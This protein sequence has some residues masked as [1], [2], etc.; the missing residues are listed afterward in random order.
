[1]CPY[2]GLIISVKGFIALWL[3]YGGFENLFILLLKPPAFSFA[4]NFSISLK[5]KMEF[6]SI[7][8]IKVYKGKRDLKY[9]L[10]TPQQWKCEWLVDDFPVF[11]PIH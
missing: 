9:H 5:N 4:L 6:D 8:V 11:F 10:L 7:S 1:M 3:W 2:P